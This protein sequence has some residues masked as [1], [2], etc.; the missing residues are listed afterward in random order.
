MQ[1]NVLTT[2]LMIASLSLVG[3]SLSGCEHFYIEPSL[4]AKPWS[5]DMEPPPGPPEYQQGYRDGC[6]SGWSGYASQFSKVF[7]TYKQD[8]ALAQK[9]IYYQIWKDAYSYCR[10]QA[11]MAGLHGYGNYGDRGAVPIGKW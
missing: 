8:T 9:P 10:T 7:F 4:K 2:V 6:Q 5:L 11:M 1:Q 3:L